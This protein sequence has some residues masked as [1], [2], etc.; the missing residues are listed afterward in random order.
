MR[1]DPTTI[2]R[3]PEGFADRSPDGVIGDEP[4]APQVDGGWSEFH[5][6]PSFPSR[7]ASKPSIS[8]LSATERRAKASVEVGSVRG[9]AERHGAR[10][11]FFTTSE[12]SVQDPRTGFVLVVR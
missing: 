10:D 5:S 9:V 8:S 6:V 12:E 2:F 3:S 4:R 11:T 7:R 1:D